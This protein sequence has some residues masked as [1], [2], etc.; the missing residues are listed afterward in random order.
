MPHPLRSSETVS[1][2]AASLLL[3]SWWLPMNRG[4]TNFFMFT[5][6]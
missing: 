1:A 4:I 6:P 2:A 5:T 3:F